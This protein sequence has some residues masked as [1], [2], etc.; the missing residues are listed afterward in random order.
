MDEAVSLVEVVVIKREEVAVCF[1]KG[2][3]L[4]SNAVVVFVDDA[5]DDDEVVDDGVDIVIFP[6]PVLP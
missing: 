6:V 4:D 3:F 1:D 5:P 2:L